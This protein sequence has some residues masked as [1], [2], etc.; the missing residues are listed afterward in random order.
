M[1]YYAMY[2]RTGNEEKVMAIIRAVMPAGLYGRCVSLTRVMKKKIHG[3]WVEYRERLLP[4]Y[5]FIMTE[6]IAAVY[7]VL[8]EYPEY[9]RILGKDEEAGNA[10]E[11]PGAG[12]DIFPLSEDE[13]E[14][15]LRLLGG[16]T[17]GTPGGDPPDGEIGLSVVGFDEESHVVVVSGPLKDMEGRV[18]KIHLHKRVA[19]VEVEFMKRTIVIQLGFD[20]LRR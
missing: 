3:E 16:G 20:M 4:G 2:V 19:D 10:A 7:Q 6:E 15:L 1:K 18:K 11:D 13:E 17:A 8:R 14:W 9:V 12:G 5:L